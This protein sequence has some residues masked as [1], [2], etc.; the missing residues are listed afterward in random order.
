MIKEVINFDKKIKDA[1]WIV[2]GE[3]KL[4]FQTL[5]GK[6]IQGVITSANDN[7]IQ[8][9]ALCGNILLPEESLDSMG[10][11]YAASIIDYATSLEDAISNSYK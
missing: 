6:T 4:D 5:S 7:N 8:V 11:L 9:A 1:N 10:I 3:G 2:T